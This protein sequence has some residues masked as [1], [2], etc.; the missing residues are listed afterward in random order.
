[1]LFGNGKGCI[2]RKQLALIPIPVRT[3]DSPYW[4]GLNH[5]YLADKI[6]ERLTAAGH[7]IVS[8]AWKVNGTQSDMFG[9][10]DIVTNPLYGLDLNM[11]QGGYFSFGVRHSNVSRYAVTFAAG[12][13][14][15][16]CSN[17]LIMGEYMS[18]RK[19]T[20]N[21][22]LDKN[23]DD[24]IMIFHDHAQTISEFVWRLRRSSLTLHQAS[25]YIMEAGRRGIIAWTHLKAVDYFWR[26]P[27]YEQFD[28]LT[29]WALFNA[30]TE[31]AKTIPAPAQMHCLLELKHLM[32][33]EL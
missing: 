31:V 15:S 18:S 24:A 14:V 10:V 28:E 25:E 4:V 3:K 9:S 20:L 11:G 29:K 6:C 33:D 30:F 21:I 7:T 17:G 2:T 32:E 22:D 26:N 8:E 23:I 27:Q 16:V 5:G 13:R 19:H 1:M 12:A